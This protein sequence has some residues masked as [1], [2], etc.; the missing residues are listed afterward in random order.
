MLE[1]LQ[2][3]FINKNE[4]GRTPL[5]MAAAN[6]NDVALRILIDQ[7][8]IDVNAQSTVRFSYDNYSK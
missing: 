1:T 4:L 5:H 8:N 2:V 7:P 6:G 3:R